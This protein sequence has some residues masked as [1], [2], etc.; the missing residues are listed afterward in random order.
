MP[1]SQLSD[2]VM[3]LRV[4]EQ[5]APAFSVVIPKAYVKRH[6]VHDATEQVV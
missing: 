4:A 5:L 1:P 6:G 3:A 2:V